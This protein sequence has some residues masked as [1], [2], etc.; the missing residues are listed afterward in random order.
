MPQLLWTRFF[1]RLLLDSWYEIGNLRNLTVLLYF[2]LCV[3]ARES[4]IL[5]IILA[6]KWCAFDQPIWAHLL[7]GHLRT[8]TDISSMWIR[9]VDLFHCHCNT[10][11]QWLFIIAMHI[12]FD[13]NC[14]YAVRT[15]NSK[16]W[17]I[18]C[19]DIS[20]NYY[21]CRW[22]LVA[23]PHLYVQWTKWHFVDV[24]RALFSGTHNNETVWTPKWQRQIVAFPICM[25]GTAK[26][27]VNLLCKKYNLW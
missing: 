12:Q 9:L 17:K 25:N 1:N 23:T 11:K 26:R 3:C 8:C 22:W 21:Y 2:V 15:Q 20:T 7:N 27:S 6:F 19:L 10:E 14:I 4:F 16:R 18:I 13:A 24:I 5:I